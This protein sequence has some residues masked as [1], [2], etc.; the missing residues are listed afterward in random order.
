MAS[1]I[2][3]PPQPR[4]AAWWP[5]VLLES[6]ARCV[7]ACRAT[8]LLRPLV[9]VDVM[10][11]GVLASAAT[12][13]LVAASA[14]TA[15]SAASDSV[16]CGVPIT[17][18]VTL[19]ADLF[20]EDGDALVVGAS[21]ITVDLAG[22]AV[23]A[24]RFGLYAA[25]RNPGYEGTTIRNGFA[26]GAYGVLL[27]GAQQNQVTELTVFGQAAAIA[28]YDS[29]ANVIRDNES[30]VSSGYG[31]LLSHAKG[32]VVDGNRMAKEND[33]GNGYGGILL[34]DGAR[35]NRIINNEAS[36]NGFDGIHVSTG[37]RENLI[38]GNTATMNTDDGIDV[39]DPDNTVRSNVTNDNGGYGIEAVKGTRGARNTASGNG[40][41]DQCLNMRCA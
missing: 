38:A 2:G 37:S 39:D 35:G 41:S 18:S 21:G 13:I 36:S 32:N 33:D 12:V 17:R 22:H 4:S 20:C 26:D 16:Q 30:F 15:A 29:R 40:A 10:R 11:L 9:E 1:L 6:D 34:T 25:V 24:P 23:T 28:I 8:L 5:I 19:S 3:G 27:V 14:P 7:S 31:I